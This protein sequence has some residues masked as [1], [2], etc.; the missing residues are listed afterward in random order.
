M[1]SESF[2]GVRIQPKEVDWRESQIRGVQ[3][4]VPGYRM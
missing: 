1:R 4:D 2:W 3:V